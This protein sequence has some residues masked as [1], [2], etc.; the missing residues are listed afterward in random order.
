MGLWLLVF[1]VAL[2][3]RVVPVVALLLWLWVGWLLLRQWAELVLVL[4]LH[5][6]RWLSFDR[7]C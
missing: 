7:A 4:G 1:V 5:V 2:H 6:V 3:L